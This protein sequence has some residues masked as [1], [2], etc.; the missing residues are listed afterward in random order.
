MVRILLITLALSLIP[1]R[2]LSDE[3]M[4]TF[5]NFPA[6][7]VG[8]AY[9]FTPSPQWLDRVRLASLRLLPAGCSA[10]FVSPNGIVMTARHC[11][12]DCIHD[13]ST[14]QQDLAQIGFVAPTPADERRCPAFELDQLVQVRNVT[15]QIR[16]AMRGKTGVEQTMALNA[17][18]A[19]LEQSCGDDAS[20]RCDLVSLYEGGVYDLY[21]YHRFTD[22]RLAF[23]PEE[24]ISYFGGDP[25]N[26]NF[27]RYAYDVCFLRAYDGGKGASASD[28]F[29]WSRN[30]SKPGE[31]T[32]VSGNPATTS[33]EL[34]VS[35]LRY[36]RDEA[37]PYWLVAFAEYRG[38]LERFSS[39]SPQRS[40]EAEPT[41]NNVENSYK[42]LLGNEK[43]LLT[44]AFF[45]AKE[46]QER[47][48][49]SAVAANPSLAGRF[50]S[51]W[52]EM[53][54]IQ[55]KRLQLGATRAIGSIISFDDS[56]LLDYALTLVQAAAE[57]VKPNAERLPE[58]TDQA[59]TEVEQQLEA[60]TPIYT[61]FEELRLGFAFT[62]AQR[63]LGPDDPFVHKLLGNESPE[64]LAQRLVRG[65]QLA[66]PKVRKALYAGGAAAIAAST[67]PMI[68]LAVT[69][70]PEVRAV[71]QQ[72]DAEFSAPSRTAAER[73]A[74]ARFAVY[75]TSI[76]PEAT[77]TL[78]LSY[79]AVK[80]FTDAGGRLVE[81]YTTIAGLYY[82][83]T[84]A[85]PFALPQSW[86]LAKASL[87]LSTPMNFVT[88]NDTIGGYSGSP[89]LN[90]EAEI[91]GVF[92]DTNIFG[93]GGNYEYEA[94]T[95]RAVFVDSRTILAGLRQVY[96][97]DR[98][99]AEIEPGQSTQR[100]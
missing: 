28:Y 52:D 50:G 91:V 96:H 53:A 56:G 66:D 40:S 46:A 68:R 10:S 67:D 64:E 87:D 73:I 88:T 98:I 81:P 59:L 14:P 12:D 18:R 70:D 97:A 5:D 13:L 22:V 80:G 15:D 23:S 48:L 84:G 62:F 33:R 19:K 86:V 89:A 3:G 6:D 2:T 4:W 77:G 69:I 57:R 41:L 44:P 29:R 31:L 74:R 42:S 83:A 32:F 24:A 51:A 38:L 72:V 7:R 25:D 45:A 20:T 78:R 100:D 79:G 34:T 92:F 82:R 43:A 36:V 61:D 35:E 30:G 49:Q 75:G 94:A 11:I 8:R 47:R 27:P 1:Q 71:R 39:E 16:A 60:P 21:R 55:G 65:T 76:D 93:L 9:G 95:N 37:W 90:R 85:P 26:F 58:F 63:Q 54:A 17:G 99:F